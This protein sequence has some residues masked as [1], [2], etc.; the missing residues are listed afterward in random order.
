MPIYG[1][2]AFAILGT[3]LL[4]LLVGAGDDRTLLGVAPSQLAGVTAML[5]L[6]VYLAGGMISPAQRLGPLLRYGLIWGALLILLVAG[7][8]VWQGLR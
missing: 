4:V 1:W 8:S 3:G 2:V 5:A 7:H 6:L